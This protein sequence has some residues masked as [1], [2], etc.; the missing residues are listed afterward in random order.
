MYDSL[1]KFELG[2]ARLTALILADEI[3]AKWECC[4]SCWAESVFALAV[5]GW[6]PD[7]FVEAAYGAALD[8][9]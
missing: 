7:A 3:V 4:P 1:G 9:E 2:S 5:L 8:H 6:T